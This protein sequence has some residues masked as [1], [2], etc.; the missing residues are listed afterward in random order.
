MFAGS[1]TVVKLNGGSSDEPHQRWKR[2]VLVGIKLRSQ[3]VFVNQAIVVRH[4]RVAYNGFI[5][6]IF[7]GDHPHV[8][9]SRYGLSLAVTDKKEGK[10]STNR[11]DFRLHIN[12]TPAR[13]ELA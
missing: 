10:K 13:L 2:A 8:G 5:T 9:R 6:V 3:S 7:L 12:K 1:R 4:L 11:E